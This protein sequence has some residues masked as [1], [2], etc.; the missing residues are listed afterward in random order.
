MKIIKS[1]FLTFNL[2][3]LLAIIA[4]FVR[5]II[6]GN[7]GGTQNEVFI[8][9]SAFL[10]CLHPLLSFIYM[11]IYFF[12]ADKSQNSFYE[13]LVIY[14]P[15]LYWLLFVLLIVNFVE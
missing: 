1:Y 15:V 3:S 6:T 12:W 10:L 2:L 4:L 9:V 13:K 5:T 11:L 8:F 14:T 7:L